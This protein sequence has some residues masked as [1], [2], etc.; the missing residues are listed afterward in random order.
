[1]KEFQ[2]NGINC[3]VPLEIKGQNIFQGQ[4]QTLCNIYFY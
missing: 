2:E 4:K 1:M 3:P